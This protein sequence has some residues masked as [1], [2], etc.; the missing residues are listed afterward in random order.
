MPSFTAFAWTLISN[1][2]FI[3]AVDEEPE[4]RYRLLVQPDGVRCSRSFA[5]ASSGLKSP[6]HRFLCPQKLRIA[7]SENTIQG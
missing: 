7:I 5:L 2:R 1:F 6:R 3:V 4:S